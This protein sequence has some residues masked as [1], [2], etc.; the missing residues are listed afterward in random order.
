MIFYGPPGTGKTMAARE[1]ARKSVWFLLILFQFYIV[2]YY[3][4]WFFLSCGE[5]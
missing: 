3:L 4:T 1:F 5:V 2:T